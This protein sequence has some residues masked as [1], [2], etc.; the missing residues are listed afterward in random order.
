MSGRWMVGVLGLAAVATLLLPVQHARADAIDGNWCYVDG[1]R[2]AIDGPAIVTPGGTATT[3]HYTRHSFSYEVPAK[4]PGAGQTV[5]MQL[6]NENTVNVVMGAD[7]GS[8][9]K[10]PVQVWH[11]CPPAVSLGERGIS[12]S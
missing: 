3:G 5:F 12:P 7:A 10:A 9:G 6:L 1:K 11:R 2:M 4:D 8:A